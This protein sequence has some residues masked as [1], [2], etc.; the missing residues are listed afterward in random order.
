MLP[1]INRGTWARVASVR[2]VLTRFLATFAPR[3]DVSRVQVLNL[4]AGFDV[5]YFWIRD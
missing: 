1:I 2:Q 3:E 5:Q 4:G